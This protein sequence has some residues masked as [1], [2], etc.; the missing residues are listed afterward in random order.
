MSG[1]FIANRVNDV[2]GLIERIT[3]VEVFPNDVYYFTE[4]PV[5][6]SPPDVYMI[7]SVAFVLALLAGLYPSWKA[8][9]MDPV[10]AIGYE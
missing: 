3:G 6:V 7:I 5:K 4:I 1:V 8:A 9:R 2:A 10:D